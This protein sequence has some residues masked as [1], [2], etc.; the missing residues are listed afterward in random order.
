M[1]TDHVTRMEG[2][3]TELTD[4]TEK[5]TAFINEN[6]LFAGLSPIDQSLMVQQ[7]AGMHQYACS[8]ALRVRRAT[9]DS[10][11]NSPAPPHP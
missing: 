11:D 2:E 6:P 8:L 3:L 5:L 9:S 1:R 7:L 4:R 10:G